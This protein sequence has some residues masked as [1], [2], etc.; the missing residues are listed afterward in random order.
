MALLKSGDAT[1]AVPILEQRLKIDNQTG[2]VQ[3]TLNEALQATGQAPAPS[4][5]PGHGRG[6]GHGNGGGPGGGLAALPVAEL[7]GVGLF[8][9]S[10]E[11]I[12]P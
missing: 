8:P 7:D 12:I 11:R 3:Q 9:T 4:K 2:V 10:S 5:T 1:D 6:H